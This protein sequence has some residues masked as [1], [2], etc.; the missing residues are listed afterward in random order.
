VH[1]IRRLMADPVGDGYAARKGIEVKRV[2][3]RL[4]RMSAT[5]TATHAGT[6]PHLASA[7]LDHRESKTTQEHYNNAS[8]LCAGKEYG[9]L[10]EAYRNP[11]AKGVFGSG[12]GT[13]SEQP[14][15]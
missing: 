1:A 3:P 7:L 6:T 11:S 9:T 15:A 2:S 4:F 8:G 12:A 10:L 14:S 13:G 5:T